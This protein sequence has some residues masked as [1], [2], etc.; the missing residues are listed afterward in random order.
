MKLLAQILWY[1]FLAVVIIGLLHY[2]VLAGANFLTIPPEVLAFTGTFNTVF[3][4]MVK[5]VTSLFTNPQK[6]ATLTAGAQTMAKTAPNLLVPVLVLAVGAIV[7]VGAIQLFRNPEWVKDNGGKLLG[8][9]F[10]KRAIP[11]WGGLLLLGGVIM[12]ILSLGSVENALGKFVI[13][14]GIAGLLALATGQKKWFEKTIFKPIIAIAEGIIMVGAVLMSFLAVVGSF[15]AV[16]LNTISQ[17]TSSPI[18]LTLAK[19]SLF[20]GTLA[21]PIPLAIVLIVVI[22]LLWQIVKDDDDDDDGGEE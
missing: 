4:W 11:F 9:I 12:Y 19:I 22:I 3:M 18:L 5:G 8:G 1:G 21:D 10:N 20:L 17:W 16:S 7:V 13:P 6:A 14:L 2:L 15:G